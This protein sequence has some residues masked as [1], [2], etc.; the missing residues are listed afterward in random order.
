MKTIYRLLLT[1]ALAVMLVI[2]F[3]T[4]AEAS[5]AGNS[6]GGIV[7]MSGDIY[8][9]QGETVTGDVVTL[10]G[11]IY[12][13]GSVTGNAVAL[14]GDI[15]VNGKVLGDAVSVTGKITVGQ[16][17]KV[18]GNTVEAAGGAITG[19][20][21]YNYNYNY[22]YNYNNYASRAPWGKTV[23]T[24]LSFFWAVVVFLLASLVYAIMPR[25]IDEMSDTIS[26]NFGKRVGIG[27]LAAI[28]SPI[29]MVILSI[30]LVVTIIG[31]LVVPFAWIAYLIICLV[32]VVPVYV[33][34]G[35]NALNLTGIKNT[36]SYAGLAAGVFALWFIKA[37]ISLGGSYTSLINTLITFMLFCLGAGTLLDYI[38]T[39][40]KMKK[41]YTKYPPYMGEYNNEGQHYNSDFKPQEIENKGQGNG[42]TPPGSDDK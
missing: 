1:V 34:I 12:I 20:K 39:N 13:N 22:K 25:K 18:M 8:V 27:I 38:F 10:K 31:I 35:K 42:E 7:R 6:E 17:G 41:A 16:N 5:T 3:G 37:V 32:A 14:F 23:G 33:F 26:P 9:N 24:I 21:S 15:I 29:V 40:R 28:G 19:K 36:S 4:A 2:P 11:N 30:I